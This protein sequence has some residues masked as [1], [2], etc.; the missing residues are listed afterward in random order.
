MLVAGGYNDNSGD[1]LAARNCTTRP[2]GP[3]RPRAASTPHASSH[4]DVAAQRQG[5]G[6]RRRYYS[7]RSCTSAELY[8]P[9]SGNLDVRRAASTSHAIRH[10]ATLLPNGKVLGA[11]G[12]DIA[13]DLA[14]RNCM[15]RPAGL[16]Q[17]RAASLPHALLSH[18]DVA[19]QWQ[20]ARR[21]GNWHQRLSC[22]RGTIR[23]GQRDLVGH[24]HPT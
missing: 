18:G 6:G 22:Q 2:A 1:Y 3:G 7:R 9:A 17:S 11:A 14:A 20:G 19:A 23:P 24:R 8:D 4:G 12:V 5:A 10:T 15:T 13:G 16:G 21:G